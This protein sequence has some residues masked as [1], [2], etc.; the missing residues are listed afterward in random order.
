MGWDLEGPGVERSSWYRSESLAS[1]EI[2][3]IDPFTLPE[4][5]T[6]YTTPDPD[7]IRRVDPRYDQGLSRALE[8]LLALRREELRGLLSLGGVVAVRLRPAGEV[9]E[10][11]SPL[12]ACRRLHAY[13]F[14][15]EISLV[16]ERQSF[17]LPQGIK[18]LPRWGSDIRGVDPAHP[19][20]GYLRAFRGYQAVL[21]CPLG[22]ELGDFGKVL[23]RNRLGDPLAW[24][25][26]VGPGKLLFLPAESGLSPRAEAELLL[27]ALRELLGME[28]ESFPVWLEHYDLPG[29]ENLR[30]ELEELKAEREE[31][32]KREG[33]LRR[34]LGALRCPKGLL[35]PSGLP[36][37]K[38]AARCSLE[39]VGFAVEEDGAD[40]WTLRISSPEGEGLVHLAWDPDRPLG[41]EA[42]RPLLLPLDRLRIEGGRPIHGLVLAAGRTAIDPRKRGRTYTDA[43]KDGCREHGLALVPAEELFRA[44][45]AVFEGADP[46]SVRR[47][48]LST[49]GPWRWRG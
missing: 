16:R 27:P 5:W 37:L 6:P 4:L 39:A 7:G 35:A 19:L 36:G 31:L 13:S 38:R 18:V 44:V 23:A 45:R 28:L 26:P 40:P 29:E 30:R 43:L 24:E 1:Y 8:N 32:E 20:T 41:A 2:V 48:L 34:K 33:E 25:V 9:L 49:V 46:E 15:P 21:I 10:I 42:Y 12:G 17:P 47:S 3:L 11:R 22:L 14:L